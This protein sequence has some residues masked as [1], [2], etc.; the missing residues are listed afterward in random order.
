MREIAPSLPAK[1]LPRVE[2]THFDEWVRA[3]KGGTPAGSNFDHA[4]PFTETV[5]LSNLAVRAQRRIEWDAA[6][7]KVTNVPAANEYVSK[8]YRPGHGV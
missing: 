2:G 5:L 7:L 6:N 3:C 1:S 8:K 4:G